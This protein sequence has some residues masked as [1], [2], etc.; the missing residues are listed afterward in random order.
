M[1]ARAEAVGTGGISSDDPEAVVKLKEELEK[2]EK[3]HQTRKAANLIVRRNPKNQPTPEKLAEL[4]EL[5][6]KGSLGTKLFEKD[7]CGRIGFPD[8]A[9]TNNGANIRRIKGRIEELSKAA[10]DVYKEQEFFEGKLKV[11]ENPDINRIQLVF[12]DKPGE[13]IREICGRC[14]AEYLLG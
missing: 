5:G 8:Y 6:L 2:A 12:D 9:L 7:F 3:V 4:E 10:A 11:V 14:G 1:K 13:K